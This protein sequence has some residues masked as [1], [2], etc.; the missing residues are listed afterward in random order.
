M[1]KNKTKYEKALQVIDSMQYNPFTKDYELIEDVVKKEYKDENSKP[2]LIGS[3]QYLSTLDKKP[4][5][6][7]SEQELRIR[8]KK[9]NLILEM[10]GDFLMHSDKTWE[11]IQNEKE[12]ERAEL[13]KQDEII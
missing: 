9:I 13:Y 1:A 2:K 11:Y 6:R 8:L 7:E 4:M 5:W 10:H 12:Q 3:L